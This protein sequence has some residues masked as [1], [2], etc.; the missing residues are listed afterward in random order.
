MK[1]WVKADEQ[2][3]NVKLVNWEVAA[4]LIVIWIFDINFIGP[5]VVG[6]FSTCL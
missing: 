4:I 6:L 3:A 2:F 5:W 1:V